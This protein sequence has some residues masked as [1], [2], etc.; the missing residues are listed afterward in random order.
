MKF[1]PEH[2]RFFGNMDAGGWGE[3]ST[4]TIPSSI[5]AEQP[6]AIKTS[7]FENGQVP[8]LC[9]DKSIWYALLQRC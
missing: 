6:L 5:C 4:R 1:P 9:W 3:T 2:P 8:N 7:E